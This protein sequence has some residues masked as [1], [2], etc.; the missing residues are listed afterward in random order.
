MLTTGRTVKAN[1]KGFLMKSWSSCRG[2]GNR[3]P[4]RIAKSLKDWKKEDEKERNGKKLGWKEKKDEKRGDGK[5]ERQRWKELKI[6][7]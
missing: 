5:R 6:I 7:G 4:G 1:F 2:V 3:A